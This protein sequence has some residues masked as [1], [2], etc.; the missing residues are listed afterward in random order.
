MARLPADVA[1]VPPHEVGI[2]LV[3]P[4]WSSPP[5]CMDCML[6]GDHSSG[7]D[8]KLD[9]SGPSTG[10]ESEG[11]FSLRLLGC[12]FCFFCFLPGSFLQK[13]VP[14]TSGSVLLGLGRIRREALPAAGRRTALEAGVQHGRGL[15]EGM[16]SHGRS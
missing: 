8:R 4:K 16:E 5:E 12:C 3:V 2:Q 14:C 10:Q 13:K 11:A 7:L 1:T 6:L 15:K 9:F